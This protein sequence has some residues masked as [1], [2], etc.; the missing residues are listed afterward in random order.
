[1]QQK[2]VLAHEMNCVNIDSKVLYVSVELKGMHI[3]MHAF[4]PVGVCT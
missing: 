1:M 3:S 4:K 2:G